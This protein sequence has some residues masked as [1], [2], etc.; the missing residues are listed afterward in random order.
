MK[1]IFCVI[2]SLSCMFFSCRHV[3]HNS[4]LTDILP[5]KKKNAFKNLKNTFAFSVYKLATCTLQ[6]DIW[7][8]TSKPVVVSGLR[9]QFYVL[10]RLALGNLTLWLSRTHGAHF[11]GMAY[12]S[13]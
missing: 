7:S 13:S 11:L 9:S 8:V 6:N 4:V 2:I 3:W 12:A 5:S 10:D 1:L